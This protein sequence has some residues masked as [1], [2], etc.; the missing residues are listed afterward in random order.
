MKKYPQKNIANAETIDE[1][2]EQLQEIMKE[3]KSSNSTM[4]Y[5]TALYLEVTIEVKK[6]IEQNYFDDNERMHKLDVIFANRYLDAY[7]AYKNSK[8]LTGVWKFAFE[9]TKHWKYIVLQHLFLGMNAHIN[10]DLGIAAA[11]TAPRDSIYSLK[12]DFNK[13]NT[14]LIN[15]IDEIQSKLTNVWP[16]LGLLDKLALRG[17][18]KLAAFSMKKARDSA[19]KNAIKL[20]HCND[21]QEKEYILALDKK[22]IDYAHLVSNPG[23][24]ISGIF[25]LVRVSEIGS[26]RKK[27]EVLQ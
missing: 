8:P 16:M 10:L 5:F 23:F 25:L 15:L 20:A 1:V 21:T 18:E 4:G 13:I 14:I 7:Y 12:N 17:D 6:K 3:S 9:E 27:I 19:W 24:F 26:V 11:Q 2:I 22:V